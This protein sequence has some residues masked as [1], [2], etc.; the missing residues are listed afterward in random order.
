M[1]NAHTNTPQPVDK[2]VHL[3]VAYDD[4]SS[5]QISAASATTPPPSPPHTH[6]TTILTSAR[7]GLSSRTHIRVGTVTIH[8]WLLSFAVHLCRPTSWTSEAPGGS[9]AIHNCCGAVR[10]VA[11]I[12]SRRRRLRSVLSRQSTLTWD[13][14]GGTTVAWVTRCGR[15][16]R[17]SDGGGFVTHKKG[18]GSLG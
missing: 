8:N 4:P 13:G 9:S 14:E 15:F 16:L 6:Q 17:E 5:L 12:G 7:N 3:L 18:G 10:L 11:T 1:T 2:Q